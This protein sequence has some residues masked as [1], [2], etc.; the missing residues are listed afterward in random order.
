[1]TWSFLNL[2][3]YVFATTWTFSAINYLFNL[4]KW[5]VDVQLIPDNISRRIKWKQIPMPMP[6]DIIRWIPPAAR[7]MVEVIIKAR[8]LEQL[9]IGLRVRAIIFNFSFLWEKF[10]IAAKYRWLTFYCV[11]GFTVI[12][13]KVQLIR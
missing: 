6:D 1:M 8:I 5:K 12:N 10:S 7:M 13:L 11:K 9:H 4:W 2:W 3:I